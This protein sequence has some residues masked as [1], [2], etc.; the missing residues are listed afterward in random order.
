MRGY[1]L[2]RSILFIGV[3][4]FLFPYASQ[5]IDFSKKIKEVRVAGNRRANSR[6][7]RFYIHSKS[8]E[9]YS[10][11]K[12]REDIRRIYDLGY[13]DDVVLLIDEEKD[14]LILTYRVKEKPF[15]KSLI[16]DG[17]QEIPPKD[18]E[19]ILKIKKGTY[20]QKHLLK[21]DT[22][23]IK[24]KYRKRGFYFTEVTPVVIPVENHQVDIIYH[25][26][27]NR[28]IKIGKIH[29]RGNEFLKDFQL[30]EIIETQEVSLF[31]MGG[32]GN[33]DRE[34]LKTDRLRIEAKYRDFGFIK[35]RI[36]KPRIEIDRENGL[37]N[38]YFFI[39]EGDQFRVGKISAEGDKIISAEDILQKVTLKE[40]E[41]FNQST[42]RQSIF[43]ITEIYTNMGY[44]YAHVVQKVD[45]HPETKTVDVHLKVEPGDKIYI[46]RITI[47][48][49]EKTHDNV[50]RREFRIHEGE[51]FQGSKMIRTR[52]RIVNTG[53]FE[54]VEIDQRSG[55][56]PD[57]ID[58]N[59]RVTE[60]PTGNIRLGAGFNTADNLVFNASI[61]ENN[62]LGT[63]RRLTLL[64]EN[65][66][67]RN[68][69]SLSLA[70][71]RFR[72][73]DISLNFRL[74]ARTRDYFTY[75]SNDQGASV[76]IG[77]SIG[78]FAFMNLQYELQNTDLTINDL[79]TA[80]F[81]L[82]SQA[83][84][85]IIGK[86][87][88]T[89]T[90]DTRD[91]F[92]FPLEGFRAT[93]YATLASTY[94]GGELDF[95]KLSFE[96]SKY[97]PL[98]K[99]FVFQAHTEIRFAGGY[100]DKGLPLFENFLLGTNRMR[101]FRFDEIGPL[102]NSGLALGGDSS[103]IF[104]LSLN[105]LFSGGI[106]GFLFYDRGQVYG[107][108]GDLSRTTANRY[109]LSNMRHDYG[110]GLRINSPMGRISLTWGFKLDRKLGESATQFQFSFGGSEF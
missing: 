46:G 31:P 79:S 24:Q 48:G 71:P 10:V 20:F 22:I 19:I 26:E 23:N 95:Y 60:K 85:N 1:V 33:Y 63:G 16:F 5:A 78:E 36:E 93:T 37:I 56:E 99:K 102:D 50:I 53:F 80:G 43:K 61:T 9:P 88:P 11:R 108:K 42:F 69:F 45:E 62:L 67:I 73:R 87:T 6:T 14:G 3:C 25:V 54:N 107:S 4:S 96:A 28:K 39:H 59:V 101:G 55:S 57:L 8:G 66:T 72:D 83:G 49:N 68:E 12:T 82:R 30:R 47:T 15:V 74:F 32:K 94:L 64:A 90:L 40:N 84:R 86:I 70:E 103:L 76:G 51:L 104:N 41:P 77:R 29:F 7:I 38:V 75:T 91:D 109:D 44:A 34:I 58:L 21:K 81:F 13:F 65:S 18:L 92:L 105:Y 97:F 110:F 35:A 17:V 52:Q 2:L 100:N 27:E 98:P 89:Y 106:A